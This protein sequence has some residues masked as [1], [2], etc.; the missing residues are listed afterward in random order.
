MGSILTQEF[1]AHECRARERPTVLPETTKPLHITN[2]AAF[3]TDPQVL[4][5]SPLPVSWIY[6]YFPLPRFFA[7]QFEETIKSEESAELVGDGFAEVAAA[8]VADYDAGEMPMPGTEDF[9]PAFKKWIKV[10]T[11]LTAA[12][13][14]STCVQILLES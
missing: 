12:R 8:I 10:T 1:G 7:L 13:T 11:A 5:N 9:A 3:G 2:G 14:S 4:L 6:T